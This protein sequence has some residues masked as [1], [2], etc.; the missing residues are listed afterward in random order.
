MADGGQKLTG[1]IEDD[2]PWLVGTI[3][4]R[5]PEEMEFAA[6]KVPAPSLVSENS[7]EDGMLPD[8]TKMSTPPAT[9]ALPPR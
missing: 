6:K 1:V 2:A 4:G 3:L 9:A 8:D 5:S 7:N